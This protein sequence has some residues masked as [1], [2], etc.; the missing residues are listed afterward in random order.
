[1]IASEQTLITLIIVG[2]LDVALMIYLA[3]QKNKNQLSKACICVLFL[4]ML[5]VI[6]IVMQITLS[7]PLNI[8]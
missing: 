7:R 1:M 8:F 4:F 5:W 2:I 6:G 3:K